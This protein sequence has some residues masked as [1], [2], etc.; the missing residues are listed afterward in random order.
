MIVTKK[1][2][3]T[4]PTEFAPPRRLEGAEQ[5]TKRRE[6]EIGVADFLL[7]WIAS[8]FNLHHLFT[9]ISFST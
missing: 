1:I 8:I 4:E 2:F 3:A 5:Q 6:R 9:S 7:G